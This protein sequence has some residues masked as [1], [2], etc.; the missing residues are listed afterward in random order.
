MPTWNR[1]CVC[2]P[3]SGFAVVV[4]VS[5]IIMRVCML[6]PRENFGGYQ[7]PKLEHLVCFGSTALVFFILKIRV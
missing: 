6:L 7:L 3:V 4:P 1:R 5:I 2:V